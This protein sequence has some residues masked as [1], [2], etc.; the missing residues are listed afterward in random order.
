M[1][2]CDW[3]DNSV[4]VLS[5]DG[6]ELVQSFKGPHSFRSPTSAVYH[7]DK[8]FVL[9]ET[10]GKVFNNEGLYLY[11][12]GYEEPCDVQV[13]SLEFTIDACNNLIVC[14]TRDERLHLFSLEGKFVYSFNIEEIKS[15]SSVAAFEDNK[16]LV[17]DGKKHVVHV[18]Q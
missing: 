1:I 4:K 7:E 11:D 14:D 10:Y 17:C 12:I 8:F 13:I 15:P 9:Y 16:L 18:L 3:A 6:T 5:P 2:V